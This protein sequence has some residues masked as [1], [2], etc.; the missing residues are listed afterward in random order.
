MRVVRLAVGLTLG[1]PAL[2]A[3]TFTAAGLF[4]HSAGPCR[5]GGLALVSSD[6]RPLCLNSDSTDAAQVRRL[7]TD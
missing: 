7:D 2:G 1:L 4:S 5:P 6:R 3:R